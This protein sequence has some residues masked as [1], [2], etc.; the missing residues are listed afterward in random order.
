[1]HDP[2]NPEKPAT[3]TRG[4]PFARG[5]PGRKR[6]SKNRAT[7]MAAALLEGEARALVREGIELALAGDVDM[8]KFFLGRILPRDRLIMLDLPP[9]EVAHDAVDALGAIM[10]AVSSGAISPKEA[11]DL[12][13]PVNSCAKAI[14]PG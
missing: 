5:N 3:I 6:G 13:V 12:A 4:R 1:M 11:A 8:L 10:R 14:E 7:V 2:G 9:I